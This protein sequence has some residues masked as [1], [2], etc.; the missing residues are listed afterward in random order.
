M[1]SKEKLRCVSFSKVFNFHDLAVFVFS[2]VSK[3][4]WN[5]ERWFVAISPISN[6]YIR[7]YD[8][9]FTWLTHTARTRY[10]RIFVIKIFFF[11]LYH[12][13]HFGLW[14]K[15]FSVW[16]SWLRALHEIGS[17]SRWEFSCNLTSKERK[18]RIKNIRERKVLAFLFEW[19]SN[20]LCS[21]YT[22]TSTAVR[23]W[24]SFPHNRSAHGAGL[25]KSQ[26]NVLVPLT[27]KSKRDRERE[28]WEIPKISQKGTQN[29]HIEELLWWWSIACPASTSLQ[30]YQPTK[31]SAGKE[32]FVIYTFWSEVKIGLILF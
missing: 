25:R 16:N 18:K 12:R 13:T 31:V 5:I 7:K 3:F 8:R 19:T 15:V 24:I 2:L 27:L 11:L 29:K 9:L 22:T 23:I 17:G 4:H 30:K 20:S 1:F 26:T 14:G 10:K 28:S 32:L 6:N 21:K